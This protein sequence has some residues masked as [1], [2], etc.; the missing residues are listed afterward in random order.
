VISK[1]IDDL[2]FRYRPVA[3]HL[4]DCPRYGT[5]VWEVT[6][7]TGD[8]PGGE[9]RE[10]TIRYACRQCG[11]VGFEGTGGEMSI[12]HTHASQV[13]YGSKPERVLGVWLHPG[14]RIWYCDDRG[15]AAYLVTAGKEPPARPEDVLGEVGWCLG[16]RHG[17][18]WGAG[19]GRAGHDTVLTSSGRTWASRR[20]AVAWVVANAGGDR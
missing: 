6:R 17:V 18:R 13:G 8:G 20:A 15:P 7:F 10:T 16:P 14:P 1:N 19:L 12:E 11:V 4:E 2:Y 5:D 3:G 9:R